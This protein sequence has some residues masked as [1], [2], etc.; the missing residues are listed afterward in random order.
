VEVDAWMSEGQAAPQNRKRNA[1]AAPMQQFEVAA[2]ATKSCVGC[3]LRML[4]SPLPDDE[5]PDDTGGSSGQWVKLQSEFR[6]LNQ[7]LV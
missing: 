4:V 3:S 6:E 2:V 1:I 5:G 7:F